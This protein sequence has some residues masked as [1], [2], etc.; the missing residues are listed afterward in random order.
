ME[1]KASSP[2]PDALSSVDCVSDPEEKEV[3]DDDDDRNHKHRRRDTRTQN[4]ERDQLEQVL[5]RPYRKYNKPFQNGHLFREGEP[6]SHY[7]LDH[8]FSLKFD[9]RRTMVNYSRASSNLD[10]RFKLNQPFPVEPGPARGRGRGSSWYQHDS[11]YTS[12]DVS[13]HMGEPGPIP[14]ATFASTGL[15]NV[16]NSQSPSWNGFGLMPGIPNGAVDA[17]HPLGW[18]GPLRST[19]NP[20]MNIR[21]PRQRCRDFEER[22]FC[23]RGDMCPMEHGVNRIVVEDVQSLSQFNL[24]VSLPSAP[25]LGTSVGARLLPSVPAASGTLI[26]SKSSHR[27]NKNRDDEDMLRLD[28]VSGPVDASGTDVYDPDQ[29]L[30]NNDCP[31]TSN[32]LL[33]MHP[34][35]ID[36]SKS[37]MDAEPSGQLVRSNGADLNLQTS[38]WGRIHTS[39][40]RI[41]VKEKV[42]SGMNSSDLPVAKMQEIQVAVSSVKGASFSGKWFNSEES[43]PKA[44]DSSS[45]AQDDI[46]R[47][48]RKPSQKAHRTLFVSFIPLRDNKREALQAHFRKFGEVIDIYIP[49]NTEQAFVQFSKREEAEAALKAPDAVMGNRFI[50]MWWANRDRILD[51]CISSGS[52]ISVMA[53]DVSS[54]SVPPNSTIPKRKDN[55]SVSI[56]KVSVTHAADNPVTP[57]SYSKAVIANGPKSSPALQ[58]KLPS[59][60]LLE[61]I[62]QK[63][64]LLDQKRNEFRRQLDKLEKQATGIKGEVPSEHASKRL[65]VEIPAASVKSGNSRSAEPVVS[66]DAFMERESVLGPQTVETS[67]SGSGQMDLTSSALPVSPSLKKVDCALATMEIE[68]P[69]TEYQLDIGP[70]AFTVTPPLPSGFADVD[71]VRCHFSSFGELPNVKLEYLKAEDGN[72]TSDPEMVDNCSALVSFRSFRAAENAFRDGKHWHGHNLQFTWV[73]NFSRES[74]PN[75]KPYRDGPI[76]Y[77]S[78]VSKDCFSGRENPSSSDEAENSAGSPVLEEDASWKNNTEVLLLEEEESYIELAMVEDD[79]ESSPAQ[80]PEERQLPQGEEC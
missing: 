50:R 34:S 38:V 59:L 30:W 62:R 27:T 80:T 13:S 1:L 11:R 28:G 10:L 42:D 17:I 73:H 8:N 32:S 47:H 26:N 74:S 7:N 79:C 76:Q 57:G 43:T 3:S 20:S 29:L 12:V 18:Q 71:A 31:D 68:V 15:P 40:D 60:E 49:S 77:A 21:I 75:S 44:G 45:K 6:Q 64:A 14:S 53:R 65:R 35:K 72:S 23:L 48:V 58:K 61:E 2:N 24:P 25:L 52:A 41:N 5:T 63:Q 56:P 70:T 51:K 37:L 22:G 33:A 66:A 55:V 36:D 19:L 46:G 54:V 16:S 67:L 39:K 78:D 69:G 9:N 4:P